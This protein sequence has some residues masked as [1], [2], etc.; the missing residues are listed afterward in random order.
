MQ[1]PFF[2]LSAKVKVLAALLAAPARTAGG[3]RLVKRGIPIPR[4]G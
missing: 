3:T 1:V 4:Y 2:C